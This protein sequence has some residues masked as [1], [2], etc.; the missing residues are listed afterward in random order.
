MVPYKE[1]RRVAMAGN[2][3]LV[4]TCGMRRGVVVDVAVVAV[5][6]TA[7]VVAVVAVVARYAVVPV[8]NARVGS[9]RTETI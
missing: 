9:T 3:L 8:E 7:P 4:F 1:G 2:S 6:A 5:A